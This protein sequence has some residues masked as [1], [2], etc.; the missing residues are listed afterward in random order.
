MRPT[1]IP[2]EL[3]REM[4]GERHVISGPAGDLIGPISPVEAMVQHLP[5]GKVYS[6]RCM[7][8]EGDLEA[9]QAGGDIWLT[10]LG[11]VVP[12]DVQVARA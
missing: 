12:F 9:L 2:D 6:I 8:E 4:P 5:S 3:A 10:F 7:L 1:I 11:H